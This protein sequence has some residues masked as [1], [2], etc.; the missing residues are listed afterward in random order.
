MIWSGLWLTFLTF[1]KR[2]R[3]LEDL[4]EHLKELY[5]RFQRIQTEDERAFSTTKTADQVEE[6]NTESQ[7]I[8]QIFSTLDAASNEIVALPNGPLWPIVS[9]TDNSKSSPSH[10][11]VAYVATSS[12]LN[13]RRML[14]AS[15]NNKSS[16]DS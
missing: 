15:G 2:K 5:E 8:H 4:V 11:E 10:E 7:A 9:I 12:P 14:P 13:Q 1:P 6:Q 3:S 16:E